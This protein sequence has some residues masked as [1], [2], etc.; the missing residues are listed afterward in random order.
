MHR[1]RE[2]RH[3]NTDAQIL[4]RGLGWFSIALGLLELAAPRRLREETGLPAPAGLVRAF[5]WREI[6]TGVA[7]LASRRP[8]AMVWGRVAGDMADLAVLA[9]TLRPDNPHRLG[10][11]GALAMVAAITALDLCIALQGDE[12]N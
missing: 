2:P 4:A 3:P 12:T 6:A 10:G 1:S 7:I 5:G 8:V 11:G 9:P